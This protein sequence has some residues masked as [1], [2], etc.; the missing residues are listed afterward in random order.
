MTYLD[1]DQMRHTAPNWRQWVLRIAGAAV[2]LAVGWM[3]LTLGTGDGSPRPEIV[4]EPG[5][6]QA[7]PAP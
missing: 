6:R 4:S 1:P 5:S 7:L 3:V 2:L